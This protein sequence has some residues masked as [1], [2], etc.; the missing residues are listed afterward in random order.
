MLPDLTCSTVATADSTFV[1]TPT[2]STEVLDLV[3]A[4]GSILTMTSTGS[5]GSIDTVVAVD[6][7]MALRTS[8]P[9]WAAVDPTVIALFGST[10]TWISS[11]SVTR[12]LRRFAR[13]VRSDRA[14]TT[15][16]VATCTWAGSSPLTITLRLLE[17][18]PAP[19]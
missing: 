15:A 2:G 5:V 7:V 19:R 11:V 16:S 9:I 17:V 4:S 18:K 1:V 13:S 10:V 6:A 14:L 12:S 8:A 3:V